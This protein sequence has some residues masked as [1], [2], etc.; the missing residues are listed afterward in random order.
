[1]YNTDSVPSNII[2]SFFIKC[3][4]ISNLSDIVICEG[5][6]EANIGS[7][8]LEGLHKEFRRGMK[9]HG[10]KMGLFISE[11]GGRF[12]KVLKVV[13][14]ETVGIRTK[15]GFEA[16]CV[17]SNQGELFGMWWGGTEGWILVEQVLVRI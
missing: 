6:I 13:I 5:F 16:N 3:L 9:V 1:M 17:V 8:P 12:L 7:Q 11:I 4:K 15:D 2:G 10:F 14:E